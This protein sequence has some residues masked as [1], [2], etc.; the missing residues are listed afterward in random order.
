M[1]L[2]LAGA[3]VLVGAFIIFNTFSITVA[4]RTRE[5]ALLRS[6]GASRRQVLAAVSSE[7]LVLGIGASA[8]GLASGLGF[9]KLLGAL[10]DAAGFGIPRSGLVLNTRTIV[11]SRS[12]SARESSACCTRSARLEGRSGRSCA[13][14]AL[15]QPS[16]ADCS[17]PP[18]GSPLRRW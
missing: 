9:A 1:L 8:L 10:F 15:S 4:Q 12:A 6:V 3:A 16:S 11:V 13:T 2:A 17:G 14:R 18:S 5:F 7:A